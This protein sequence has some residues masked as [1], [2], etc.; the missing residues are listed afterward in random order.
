VGRIVIRHLVAPLDRRCPAKRS[1]TAARDPIYA[2]CAYRAARCPAMMLSVARTCTGT[3]R[4]G[5]Q[6]SVTVVRSFVRAD[7]E[8]R[9]CW[10][11]PD[12]L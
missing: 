1:G 12:A 5:R 2:C 9:L 11:A 8:N 10:L 6:L 3:N 7:D 4:T